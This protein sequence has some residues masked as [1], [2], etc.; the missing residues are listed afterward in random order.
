MEEP[1]IRTLVK[2][3]ARPHPSGGTVVEGTAVRAEGSDFDAVEAW[4]LARGA[5]PE[6]EGPQTEARGL[7]ASRF[8]DADAQRNLSTPRYVLPPGAL[9]ADPPDP[10]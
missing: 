2:R 3:L 7:Y 6:Q 10:E 8:A 5:Q 4:M 9:D 1:E